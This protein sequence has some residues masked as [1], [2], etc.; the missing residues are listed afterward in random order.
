MLPHCVARF[1]CKSTFKYEGGDHVILVGEVTAFDHSQREPLVF[2]AGRYVQA[3]Q[4]AS[5]VQ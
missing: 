4:K 5:A 1:H 3:T 2:Q